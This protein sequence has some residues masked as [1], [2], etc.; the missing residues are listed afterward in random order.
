[1]NTFKILLLSLAVVIALSMSAAAIAAPI[2]TD[3]P[4][5]VRADATGQAEPTHANPPKT[6]TPEPKKPDADNAANNARVAQAIANFFSVPVAQINAW[7]DAGIGYGEIIKAYALAQGS[8]KSVES[9]FASRASEQGWG[10]IVRSLAI[11]KWTTNL[12]KVMR[13]AS[14]NNPA[15][16]TAPGKSGEH[17][18][19][20]DTGK[21]KPNDKDDD[22]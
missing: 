13:G 1:M 20:T 3:Q 21:G 11:A 5:M 10:Q 19:D 16:G 4:S 2:H 18:K 9:I 14:A 22:D 17:R 15:I 12:G 6:K 8:G 7:H